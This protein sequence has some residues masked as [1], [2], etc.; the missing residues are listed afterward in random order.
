MLV[1]RCT[2]PV[3]KLGRHQ[4]VEHCQMEVES[5]K[6]VKSVAQRQGVSTSTISWSRPESPFILLLDDPTEYERP[7]S[8]HTRKVRT[9]LISWNV[10]DL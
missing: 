2:Q 4:Y 1:L 7:D 8:A 9:Y 10:I 5:L 3:Y 6:L